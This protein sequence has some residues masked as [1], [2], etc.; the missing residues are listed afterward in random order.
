MLLYTIILASIL[1][2]LSVCCMQEEVSY[3]HD[4]TW[5]S[6]DTVGGQRSLT[7]SP[8]ASRIKL[9]NNQLAPTTQDLSDDEDFQR[10]IGLEVQEFPVLDAEDDHHIVGIVREDKPKVVCKGVC[11]LVLMAAIG[12]VSWRYRPYSTHFI[13][14]SGG[15]INLIYHKGC[16]RDD[17]ASPC[18]VRLDDGHHKMLRSIGRLEDVG[19]AKDSSDKYIAHP[20]QKAL[21]SCNRFEVISR[22]VD[23]LSFVPLCHKSEQH[24][25]HTTGFVY[26][27]KNR[28][29]ETSSSFYTIKQSGHYVRGSK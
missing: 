3:L 27:G 11:A 4:D 25:T 17:K 19:A 5:T 16:A 7:R 21:E 8:K 1:S 23:R 26:D 6:D 14:H 29:D 9:V 20:T 28:T 12:V 24:E 15:P 18:H 22:D 2:Y 10:V 13:N